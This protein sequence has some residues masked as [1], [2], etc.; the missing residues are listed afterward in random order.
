M[1]EFVQNGFLMMDIRAAR[2][3]LATGLRTCFLF[4]KASNNQ[5]GSIPSGIVNY[6]RGMAKG[7]ICLAKALGITDEKQDRKLDDWIDSWRKYEKSQGEKK[8]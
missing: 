7:H 3:K 6:T 1:P 8:A 2:R 4:L 5:V